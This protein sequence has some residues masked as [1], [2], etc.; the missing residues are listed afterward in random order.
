M[1]KI[2]ATGINE[3][4]AAIQGI[5]KRASDVRS[6]ASTEAKIIEGQIQRTFSSSPPTTQ[7]AAV[8]G[9]VTWQRLSEQY[10]R[11]VPRRRGGKTLIDTGATRD[12]FK[13]GKRNNI[14][15][16]NGSTV[17]FGSSEPKA[18]WNQPTRP[19]VFAH[20]AMVEAVIAGRIKYILGG[21]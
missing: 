15:K 12:S 2:E 18:A 13:L 19:M 5:V 7:T 17:E 14:F 8:Y 11:Q 21:I 9:G 1:L 16:T 3:A 10:L 6:H 20:P 4:I